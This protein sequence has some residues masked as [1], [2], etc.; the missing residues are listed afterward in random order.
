MIQTKS[1]KNLGNRNPHIPRCKTNL[2]VLHRSLFSSACNPHDTIY[3]N[4]H[5]EHPSDCISQ[6]LSTIDKDIYIVV[7][8]L[9]KYLHPG[10]V[11]DKIEARLR[12]QFSGS[13]QFQDGWSPSNFIRMITRFDKVYLREQE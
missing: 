13:F 8:D 11:N 12:L 4:S 7:Q 2:P 10:V 3:R 6:L 1:L 5:T 9:R